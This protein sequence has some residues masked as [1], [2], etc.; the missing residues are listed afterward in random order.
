MI[1]VVCISD[2]HGE[3]PKEEI[4]QCDILIIAGD[5][6]PVYDHSSPVRVTIP[7]RRERAAGRLLT[8]QSAGR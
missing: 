7:T 6:F 1:D 2:L 4:P 8:G 3:F 5:I